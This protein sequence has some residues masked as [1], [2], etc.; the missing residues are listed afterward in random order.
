MKKPYFSKAFIAF[1]KQLAA[2]NNREWFQAQRSTYESQVK[3]PMELFV[4]DVIRALGKYDKSIAPLRPQDCIFRINRDIRFSNDKSPYKLH[5][6]AVVSPEGKKGTSASGIYLE[7]GPEKLAFAA[8]VYMPDKAAL[9]HI[10]SRMAARPRDFMKLV[11][12]KKFTAVWG[13][14][15]GDK[16]KL[17]AP[18]WKKA[19]E[20]CPYIYHKQFY[21]WAELPVRH[22]TSADLMDLVVLHYKTSKDLSTWLQKAMKG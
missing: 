3:K 5:T 2:N 16:N 21:C 10:R 20:V 7:L 15:Q 13:T 9:L 1:F 11:Q 6:S 19:A 8:G 17:I 18:E 4:G 12:D 22:I 14:L